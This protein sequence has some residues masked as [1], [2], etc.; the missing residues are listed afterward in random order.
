MNRLLAVA[1]L[2]VLNSSYAYSPSGARPS[3]PSYSR[4]STPSYSKPSGTSSYKY[5]PQS[6]PNTF[7]IPSSE[8]KPSSSTT[9]KIPTSQVKPVLSL[10]KSSPKDY[11]SIYKSY[12]EA[13]QKPKIAPKVT[14]SEPIEQRRRYYYSGYNPPTYAARAPQAY[15]MWDS[16]L[17]WSLLDN[18]GDQLM[19]YQHMNDPAFQQWRA[20]A[21]SMASNDPELKKKLEDLD[22]RMKDLEKEGI[23]KDPTYVTPGL[24][25][26]IYATDKVDKSKMP[27]IRLC[28]GSSSGNYAKISSIIHDKSRLNVDIVKTTGS[29]E[30]VNKLER[31]ECDVALV[32]DDIVKVSKPNVPLRSMF[33]VSIEILAFVCNKG[34]IKEKEIGKSTVYV[35]KDQSGSVSTLRVMK[36]VDYF[37]DISITEVPTTIDALSR[38]KTEKA[39]AFTVTN[40]EAAVLKLADKEENNRLLRV[41]DLKGLTK[42]LAE[43]YIPV[44][45]MTS[46]YENLIPSWFSDLDG[47]AVETD[48]V[49]TESW[50]SNH[51]TEFDTLLLESE[52][53]KEN[54]K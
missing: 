48:L 42:E 6:K 26:S 53:L 8:S 49:V 17:M 51:T 25:P 45:I 16:M 35:G 23:P 44:E 47:Y 34:F 32:Q 21:N 30:N 14:Y 54:L 40:P 4:P 7:K 29:V 41:A 22:S 43:V 37:K 20:Q 11:S 2:F 10:P 5:T 15:G 38:L 50:I 52:K 28:T 13:I 33:N 12:K 39:C 24:D 19:Y 3:T 46:H 1:C 9:F 27:V 18:V 31:N 36:A